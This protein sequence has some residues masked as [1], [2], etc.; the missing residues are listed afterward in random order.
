MSLLIREGN[1]FLVVTCLFRLSVLFYVV[2]NFVF[3]LP[4]FLS[5]ALAPYGIREGA[6]KLDTNM[7]IHEEN[8]SV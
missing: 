8:E 6:R 7:E 5:I 2:D 4:F 1:K 3:I